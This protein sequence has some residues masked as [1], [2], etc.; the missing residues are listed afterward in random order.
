MLSVALAA[1]MLRHYFGTS[2][3]PLVAV[4]V[5]KLA[6]LTAEQVHAEDAVVVDEDVDVVV[7]ARQWQGS[8]GGIGA[9]VCNVYS[10]QHEN[11]R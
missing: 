5:D 10:E 2:T 9:C 8:N 6:K 11:I 3:L 1:W 4:I 7:A